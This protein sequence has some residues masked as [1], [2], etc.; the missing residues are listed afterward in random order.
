MIIVQMNSIPVYKLAKEQQ[1]L[2]G[3]LK[4]LRSICLANKDGIKKFGQIEWLIQVKKCLI[5]FQKNMSN[6]KFKEHMLTTYEGLQSHTHKFP[7]GFGALY[8]VMSKKASPNG[9]S[10]DGID[11]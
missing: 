9:V 5:E 7:F 1:C 10:W 6:A 2:V 3:T 8:E 11:M 4:A